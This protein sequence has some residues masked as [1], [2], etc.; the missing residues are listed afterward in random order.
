MKKVIIGTFILFA[1]LS[2]SCSSSEDNNIETPIE[3]E[4]PITEVTI[5]TQIWLQ[6]NL[7]VNRYRNGDI[8]PE[9]KDRVAWSEL[10]TG[11]WCYYNNDPENRA[12]YGKLYNGYAMLD[13][14]GLAPEGWHIPDDTEWMTLNMYL[15]EDVAGKAMKATTGWSPYND[16]TNSSGFTGFPGGRRANSIEAPFVF[17]GQWGYWWSITPIDDD[18]CS[19]WLLADSFDIL[20]NINNHLGVGKSVRCVKD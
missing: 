12:T 7:D 5:G 13:P 15:G 14:R 10:T 20:I 18:S 16:G 17:A 3:T 4:T 19:Y 1:V 6:K 8:I 11:A 2:Y 9:V